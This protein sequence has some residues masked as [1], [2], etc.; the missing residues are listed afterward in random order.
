MRTVTAYFI[1]IFNEEEDYVRK[2]M[3]KGYFTKRK[4]KDPDKDRGKGMDNFLPVNWLG[5]AA[6]I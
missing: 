1:R 3:K 5:V 2:D 4:D 6:V